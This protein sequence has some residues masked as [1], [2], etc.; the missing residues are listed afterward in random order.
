MQF[1]LWWLT[2]AVI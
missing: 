2:T 1:K